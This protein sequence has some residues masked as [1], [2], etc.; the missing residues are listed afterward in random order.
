M[1]KITLLFLAIFAFQNSQ[2]VTRALAAAPNT[3]ATP[4]PT[5][6]WMMSEHTRGLSVNAVAAGTTSTA[7]GF[8]S[9][10][11]ET[12]SLRWNLGFSLT[13]P[14]SGD[15]RIG[16]DLGIGYRVYRFVSGSLKGFTEP[17]FIFGKVN[18]GGG[19]GDDFFIG[20]SYRFGAEYF[21]NPNLSIGALAGVALN[22]T[23]GFDTINLGTSSTAV[24]LN[25]YW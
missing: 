9:F 13:K 2:S 1:K 3:T 4:N 23:D 12:E 17:G 22:F 11:N 19:W 7:I 8:T 15:A 21:F 18:A 10:L 6:T 25:W 5:A 20:F 24:N 16:M 14:N